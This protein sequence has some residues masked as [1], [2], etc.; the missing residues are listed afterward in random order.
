MY[1]PFRV[2]HR[3]R[4]KHNR[5]PKRE[6]LLVEELRYIYKKQ[7]GIRTSQRVML[8]PKLTCIGECST[9]PT[10]ISPLHFFF[11]IPHLH[12]APG[13]YK[14][15]SFLSSSFLWHCPQSRGGGQTGDISLGALSQPYGYWLLLICYFCILQISLYSL[16]L[17]YPVIIN[18]HINFPP[19]KLLC[20]FCL[21]IGPR[22]ITPTSV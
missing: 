10:Y 9:F 21:L 3:R 16:L 1:T 17:Q 12:P 20:D 15:H 14:T 19:F 2:G 11:S 4:I 18:N 8:V 7:L 22:L 5:C 13:C 6:Y